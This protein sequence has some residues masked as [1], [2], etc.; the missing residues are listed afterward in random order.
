MNAEAGA[1]AGPDAIAMTDPAAA[2]AAARARAGD[3][4]KPW[5][6]RLARSYVRRQ[7]ATE[8][9]G[10]WV[11]GLAPA[12][13]AQAQGPVLFV[14][15]HVAWWDP[16]LVLLLDAALGSEGWAV[17]DAQSLRKLPFL[18]WVG[19]LPLDRSGPATSRAGLEAAAALLD[20]PGRGLWIFPQGR[21]RPAHVRPLDLKPGVRLL[22]A[23]APVDVITVSFNYIFLEQSRPAAMVRFSAPLPGAAVGGRALL[24]AIEASL[25]D[26]LAEIDAAALVATDGRQA[27]LQPHAPLPDFEPL[28]LPRSVASH[29][30]A[31]GRLLRRLGG[32]APA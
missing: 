4:R 24:G 14:A 22:H 2:D 19:G 1:Q 6:L 12:R 23:C 28:V 10:L 25:L 31:G 9:D 29:Q 30:G 18:G 16:M 17:M 15:N 26:G 7:V 5:F 8:L 13:A 20:R 32:G 27:A 11:R 3:R 21:Q